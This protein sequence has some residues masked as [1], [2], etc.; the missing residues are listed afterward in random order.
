MNSSMSICNDVNIRIKEGVGTIGSSAN[1]KEKNMIRAK[2]LKGVVAMMPAFTT[3]DAGS[4]HATDTVDTEM[5]T[6]SVDKIIRDG[7]NAIA[8]MRSF[9]EF[10]TLLW[11]EKK[12]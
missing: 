6:T 3:K 8:T 12:K 10:H 4:P 1:G 2:D 11:E 7:A 9:G 5:L